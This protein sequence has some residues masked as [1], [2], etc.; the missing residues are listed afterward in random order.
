MPD[1]PLPISNIDYGAASGDNE[2]EFR[3]LETH[4]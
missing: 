4:A 1:I 3:V 2:G